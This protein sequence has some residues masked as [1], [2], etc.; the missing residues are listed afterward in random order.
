M[1]Q[2]LFFG[3][4]EFCLSLVFFGAL[5]LLDLDFFRWFRECFLGA[6]EVY[7]FFFEVEGAFNG[8]VVEVFDFEAHFL[9]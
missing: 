2:F 8:A 6:S 9:G 1:S 7:V 3:D 5:S 4:D